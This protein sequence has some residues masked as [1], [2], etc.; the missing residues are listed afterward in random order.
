MSYLNFKTGSAL[1]KTARSAQT[2][3][4][5]SFIWIVWSTLYLNLWVKY[6]HMPAKV[7][8]FW[9]H[10]P[11]CF[12]DIMNGWSLTDF[13]EQNKDQNQLGWQLENPMNFLM[14]KRHSQFF[15]PTPYWIQVCWLKYFASFCEVVG[16]QSSILCTMSLYHPGLHNGRIPL[17]C[18]RPQA[19]S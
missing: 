12:A 6:H 7:E 16:L 19:W 11:S 18:F 3:K 15:G 17:G 10:P 2:H 5:I 9:T 1:P 14:K 4:S 8:I 13:A